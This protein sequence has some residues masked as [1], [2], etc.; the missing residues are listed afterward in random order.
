MLLTTLP[1]KQG[2]LESTTLQIKLITNKEKYPHAPEFLPYYIIIG[3]QKILVL[4]EK[5]NIK[6]VICVY[7][8][9]KVD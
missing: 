8:F 3:G 1:N 6:S 9:M 5:V 7:L 2:I 4:K